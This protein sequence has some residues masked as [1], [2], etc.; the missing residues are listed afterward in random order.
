MALHI[1]AALSLASTCSR[2][3]VAAV[4]KSSVTP[5]ARDSSRLINLILVNR[6]SNMATTCTQ[7]HGALFSLEAPLQLDMETISALQDLTASRT[8]SLAALFL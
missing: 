1:P 7:A 3:F 5:L 4:A 8:A 2:I 6:G